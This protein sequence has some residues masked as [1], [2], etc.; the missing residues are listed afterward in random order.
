MKKFLTMTLELERKV[1]M[2]EGNE[3]NYSDPSDNQLVSSTN[4]SSPVKRLAV[5]GPDVD[6][7]V[8]LPPPQHFG[9][10]RDVVVVSPAT[11][12]PRSRS[13]FLRLRLRL[14][15]AMRSTRPWKASLTPSPVLADVKKCLALTDS[16]YLDEDQSRG[17]RPSWSVPILFRI[18]PSE[19]EKEINWGNPIFG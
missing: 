18:F 5:E 14:R 11:L 1:L 17:V 8:L 15:S 19:H 6:E 13:A 10:P 16:A 9:R 12:R 4:R 3:G 2:S 7:P